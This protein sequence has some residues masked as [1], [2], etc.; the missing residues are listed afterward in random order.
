MQ[1]LDKFMIQIDNWSTKIVCSL[2]IRTFQADI[3]YLIPR[4]IVVC[5]QGLV[6]KTALIDLSII[7]SP[8][9]LKVKTVSNN[10]TCIKHYLQSSMFTLHDLTTNSTFFTTNITSH[11]RVL[12]FTKHGIFIIGCLHHLMTK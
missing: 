7:K 12:R 1:W 5:F 4:Q 9:H 2:T 10:E 11:C 3:K 8:L 6:L